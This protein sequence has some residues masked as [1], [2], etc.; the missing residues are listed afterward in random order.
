MPG[1]TN[2]VT[3]PVDPPVR[4]E[5]YGSHL[6]VAWRAGDLDRFLAVALE[7]VGATATAVVDERGVA[8]RQER[9]VESV[10]A[11]DDVRYVRVDSGPSVPTVAWERRTTPVV[12]LT[13]TPTAV[14]C[15]DL[16]LATTDCAGWEQAALWRAREVLGSG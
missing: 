5:R 8:G 6:S 10:A 1:D 3:V 7:V 4:V 13:G 11:T 2:T 16:H 14:T 9:P 15:R 12:T